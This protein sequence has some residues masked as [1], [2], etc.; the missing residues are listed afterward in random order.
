MQYQKVIFHTT[1]AS[2]REIL[3]A[4]LSIEGYDGFEETDD[5]LLAYIGTDNYDAETLQL[6]A[7]EYTLP[8][9]IE[10]VGQQNWNAEWEKNFQ[11][12]MVDDFCT[13]R[14]DFHNLEVHTAHDIIITPKMSFGTGHHAT[15]RMMVSNMRGINFAG[16]SVLDFGTGTGILAI[17]AEKL[18][19][20]DILAVDN[21][22]WAYE[23]ILENI[24]RNDCHHII[25]KQGSLEHLPPRQYDVIL[26]N[27]NRHILLQYMDD[28]FAATIAGGKLLMSGLLAEDEA[29]I[30][31]A[32]GKA[33]FKFLRTDSYNNWICLEYEK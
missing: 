22:E 18:G 11:P 21:D 6:I 2:K 9:E 10:T 24:E 33:G 26:A 27:I 19:A 4:R 25:T 30:K 5:A 23:N 32:A 15:T 1:E 31:D 7:D 8:Y 3:I 28:M 29:I 17:L 16:T 20:A 12:V 14:A 13:I